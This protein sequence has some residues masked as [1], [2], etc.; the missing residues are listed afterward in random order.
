MMVNGSNLEFLSVFDMKSNFG[1]DLQEII[2]HIIWLLVLPRAI[3]S[4]E[5]SAIRSAFN[6]LL[7]VLNHGRIL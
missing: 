6:F 7:K 1:S 4:R 2:K 3:S 5:E